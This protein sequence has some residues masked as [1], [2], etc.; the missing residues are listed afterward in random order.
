MMPSAPQALESLQQ[1]VLQAIRERTP[2][3]PRAGGSKRWLDPD[4][5][6]ASRAA[7]L[8]LRPYAGVV[9]HEPSEL[10]LTARAGT[11]LSEVE[12][13]LAEHGQ[14]LPFDPPRFARDGAQATI[15][16]MVA[17]GLSGP[18]RLGA[19]AVRDFVLGASLLNGRAEILHFGGQVMKNVA[20]FDVSRLLAGSMGSLGAILEV[21]LK[22]LPVVRAQATLSFEM[23]Q[24]QAIEAINR[25]SGQPLPLSASA[26]WADGDGRGRLFVRLRGARATVDSARVRLGGECLEAQ[27]ADALWQEL[28]EQRLDWFEASW[29][30]RAERAL[31][32]IAVPSAT[33][34]LPLEGATLIE[35]GGAQRWLHGAVDAEQVRSVAAAVGGHAT[36]FRGGDA[37]VAVFSPPSPPLDRI[38]RQLKLAFDPHGLFPR[39]FGA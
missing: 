22:V 16:G 12:E 39:C 37:A 38:H 13:R 14:C 26:W 27:Q 9:A 18:G 25:W 17:A 2:L 20:G 34:P 4:P 11:P 28:R 7:V 29:Q 3:Q 8:D 36:R 21:S 23:P 10:Y 6:H 31:W 33:P 5:A 30:E 15:G 32:R 19:G 35:W 24:A 1:Q